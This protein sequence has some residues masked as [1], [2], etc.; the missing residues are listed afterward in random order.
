LQVLKRIEI[1]S[2]WPKVPVALF[3]QSGTGKELVARAIHAENIDYGTGPFIPVNCATM[4]GD[5]VRAELFGHVKG[6]YTDAIDSREGL[7]KAAENGTIF[8]DEIEALHLDT[9]AM[10]L[11]TLETKQILPVGAN[12]EVRIRNVR[13]IAATNQPLAAMVK[14]GRFRHDLY[15]RLN[16][17]PIRLPTL[18]ERPTDIPLLAQ[19]LLKK[20][21][22]LYDSPIEQFSQQVLRALVSQSWLGN[23]REL[24]NL[25]ISCIISKKTG[26]VLELSDVEQEFLSGL[27]GVDNEKEPSG[28]LAE[29]KRSL[30]INTLK[31]TCGQRAKAAV[32]MGISKR[33]L[34]RNMKKFGITSADLQGV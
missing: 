29:T 14:Q 9:Q 22:Q 3:G 10:L 6:A 25:V 34:N 15:Y 33:T 28:S 23:V 31:K 5:I 1:V 12:A 32:L 24:E 30:I 19:S 20:H 4:H 7:F 8:L 27:A 17:F 2:R 26:T 16:V 18:E 21:A 11:R 13:V